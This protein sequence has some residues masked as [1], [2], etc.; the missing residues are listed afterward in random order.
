MSVSARLRYALLGLVVALP[1]LALQPP[2]QNDSA[3][4]PAQTGTPPQPSDKPVP[5]RKPV[6]RQ[7]PDT[8]TPSERIEADSAVSFP[9]DI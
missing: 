3:P 9:V 6:P 1:V 5:G 8:I 7:S 4:E 2:A